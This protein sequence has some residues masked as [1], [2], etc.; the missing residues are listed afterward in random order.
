MLIEA[1]IFTALFGMEPPA[2][3]TAS[4]DGQ[5]CVAAPPAPK[6]IDAQPF[7]STATDG[8]RSWGAT[9]TYRLSTG[10]LGEAFMVLNDD[11]SGEAQLMI[12]GEIIAHVAIELPGSG[13]EP[14]S[15]LTTWLPASVSAS[16]D[17]LAEMMQVDLP[18]IVAGSIPQEF[19]CSPWA[20]KMLRAGKYMWTGLVTAGIAACCA[21]TG[22]LTPGCVICA[23]G[24]GAGGAY[25]GDKLGDH[26]D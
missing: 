21:G 20:K 14:V 4:V 8:T 6:R 24:L 19:K 18:V 11:G 16:P 13:P 25:V 10:A 3:V 2:N 9:A 7:E 23:G 15:A 1:V 26:C 22:V 5:V 17:A 12:D